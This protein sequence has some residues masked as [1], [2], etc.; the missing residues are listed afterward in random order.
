MRPD[1]WH[2]SAALLRVVGIVAA[3]VTALL[4]FAPIVL[5]QPPSDDAIACGARQNRI[6]AEFDMARAA[7]IWEIFPAM[8]RAPELE[9]D[10][11][12]AHVVVF[13]GDFDMNGMVA[14]RDNIPLVQGAVCVVQSDGT[15]N[16]YDSVSRAGAKLP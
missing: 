6:E 1:A 15:P 14:G 4:I 16:L 2:P 13:L 7:D 3:C 5:S 12:P 9:A 8:L 11:S 10:G